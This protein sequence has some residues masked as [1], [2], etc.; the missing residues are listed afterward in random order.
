MCSFC[1]G[2]K[3]NKKHSSNTKN[4]D[5]L[6]LPKKVGVVAILRPPIFFKGGRVVPN[7]RKNS[8]SRVMSSFFCFRKAY[9]SLG[10]AKL[11]VANKPPF[12]CSQ[13][14][15]YYYIHHCILQK[16]RKKISLSNIRIQSMAIICSGSKLGQSSLC[17]LEQ[18]HSNSSI[19]SSIKGQLNW[20][21]L[22]SRRFD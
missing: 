19:V 21:F 20:L 8:S 22:M 2:N 4:G 14:T 3:T 7:L 5:C 13:L 6:E 17:I 10:T 11:L 15:A 16:R 1:I 9:S 18:L 12:S